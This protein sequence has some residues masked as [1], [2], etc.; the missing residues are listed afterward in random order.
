MCLFPCFQQLYLQLKRKFNDFRSTTAGQV[1]L[2]GVF[3]YLIFSGIYLKILYFF[4]MV[5][6]FSPLFLPF[7]QQQILKA[8]QEAQ[9]GNMGGGRQGQGNP[10]Y[11]NQGGGA[12]QGGGVGNWFDQMRQASAQKQNGGWS[13]RRGN[14]GSRGSQKK[15]DGEDIIVDAEWTSV[16]D[17]DDE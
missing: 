3:I 1:V 4:F 12:N 10:F 15:N 9:Q 8:Q 16:S 6:L 14:N 5:S 7:L 17:D 13:N 11:T 2:Y